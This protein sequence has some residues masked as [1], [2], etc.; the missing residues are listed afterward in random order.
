MDSSYVLMAC[1][2]QGKWRAH[3]RTCLTAVTAIVALLHV[4]SWTADVA[5]QTTTS[6]CV[7]AALDERAG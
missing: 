7:S 1:A 4:V 5:N 2:A 3:T 6:H